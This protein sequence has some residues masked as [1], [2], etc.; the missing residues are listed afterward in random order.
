[1][2]KL[3]VGLIIGSFIAVGYAQSQISQSEKNVAPQNGPTIE[4]VK[5][6]RGSTA[7]LQQST[8]KNIKESPDVPPGKIAFT[9]DTERTNQKS[10][11]HSMSKINPKRILNTDRSNDFGRGKEQIYSKNKSIKKLVRV[12]GY[13]ERIEIK[14]I[15]GHSPVSEEVLIRALGN[16]KPIQKQSN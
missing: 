6:K 9:R 14:K 1:M 3:M 5:T 4:K 16:Q 7:D 15:E 12:E 11:Y 10:K 8:V 13:V 2:K